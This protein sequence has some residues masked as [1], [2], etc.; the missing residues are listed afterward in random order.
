MTGAPA[1]T[2]RKFS[3]SSA[4]PFAFWFGGLL[5][6]ALTSRRASG[7]LPLTHES[8]TRLRNVTLGVAALIPL[9]VLFWIVAVIVPSASIGFLF[10]VLGG[11]AFIVA[12]VAMLIVRRTYGPTGKVLEP[13]AG[14]LESLVELSNVHPAFVAAVQQLQQMRA[15][16]AYQRPAPLVRNWK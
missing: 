14:H 8:V 7:Y 4:P 2:W 6:A 12:V 16:N 10:A 15:Q 3:F 11:A 9:A 5:V 13:K 1:E